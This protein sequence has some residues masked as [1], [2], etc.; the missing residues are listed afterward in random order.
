MIQ[1]LG[2][3]HRKAGSGLEDALVRAVDPGCPGLQAGGRGRP[4]GPPVSLPTREGEAEPR[5]GQDSRG[6][7]AAIQGRE[8]FHRPADVPLT[9]GGV[10]IEAQ[11]VGRCSGSFIIKETETETIK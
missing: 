5:H 7:G 3:L 4:V 9:S 1:N 2:P 6:D 8:R 11:R 10:E